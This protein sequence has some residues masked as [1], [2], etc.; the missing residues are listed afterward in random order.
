MVS[1]A[2][3]VVAWVFEDLKRRRSARRRHCEVELGGL[4]IQKEVAE[5]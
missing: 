2:I 5:S 3:V 4:E 1:I